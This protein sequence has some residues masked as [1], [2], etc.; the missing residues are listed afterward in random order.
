MSSTHYVLS[1]IINVVLQIETCGVEDKRFAPGS[2]SGVHREPGFEARLL[3]IGP[4]RPPNPC[5]F[6]M[7]LEIWRSWPRPH[8]DKLI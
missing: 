4:Q 8:N 5:T 7:F 1:T 2:L 6:S 3:S